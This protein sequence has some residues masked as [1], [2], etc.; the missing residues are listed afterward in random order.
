[1][2]ESVDELIAENDRRCA[3][4]VDTEPEGPE[5]PEPALEYYIATFHL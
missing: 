1:M 4:E 2:F 3:L 5:L